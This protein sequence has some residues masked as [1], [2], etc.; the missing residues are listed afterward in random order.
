MEFLEPHEDETVDDAATLCDL[1]DESFN[2][3]V[4][5]LIFG[6]DI[7]T[8]LRVYSNGQLQT[9]ALVDVPRTKVLFDI[10]DNDIN[11]IHRLINNNVSRLKVLMDLVEDLGA[12][13]IREN[14]YIRNGHWREFEEYLLADD[15]FFEMDVK[16]TFCEFFCVCGKHILH[17]ECGFKYIY[18]PWYRC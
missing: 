11:L 4:L 12:T 1:E 16:F 9:D 6:D 10:V 2:I 18:Y 13:A 5:Q 7:D 15:E 17:C 14:G 3:D 8:L